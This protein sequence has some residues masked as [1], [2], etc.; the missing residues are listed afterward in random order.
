MGDVALVSDGDGVVV[1]GERSDIERFLEHADLLPAAERFSLSKLSSV[2]KTGSE[3]AKTASGAA[4]QSAYYLKVT[5]ETAKRIKDAGGLMKT[6]TKGISFAMLG[7]PGSIGGWL[8]VE[9]GPLSLLTN[10]AVL[11][12][13][14]GLM[15]QVAHQTEAQA[16]KALLVTMDGKLDDVRRTQRDALLAKMH[17][18]AEA[19]ED[20]MTLREHG[21]DAATLWSKVSGESSMISEVQNAALLRLG[22]LADKVDGT[23]KVGEL[24]RTSREVERETSVQLA[25]LARCFEL[26]DE[27]AVVELDHVLATAPL[28]LDGHRAGLAAAREMRRARV[29]ERTKRLMERMDAVGGVA[30]ANILVHARA[31]RAVIGSLNSTAAL[32]DD[33]HAPLGIESSR[34]AVTAVR[35][36]DAVRD[37]EHLKTAGA[38]VGQKAAAVGLVATVIAAG[39]NAV[40]N[41]PKDGA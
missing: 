5:P 38:E 10:P 36:R 12:G 6:K 1:A 23:T 34:E 41:P 18:S 39:T 35:W 21:G 20:A 15:S 17:R 16:L 29:L 24:K 33:F 13:I 11:S 3:L 26:Q 25:I 40:K 22:A 30:N 27:F 28:T 8:Q 37:V 9:D 31:A 4:E 7:D 2:I 14:G 19:I 32:V